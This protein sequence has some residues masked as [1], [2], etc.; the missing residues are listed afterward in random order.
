[1]AEQPELVSVREEAD[2]AR[3]VADRVLDY[4]EAG[5]ALKA[6]AVLFRASHHSGPLEV[7]LTRR[8]IP[9]VKFGGLRFVGA[10]RLKAIVALLRFRE[11]PRDRVAGSR[12]LQLMPGIGAVT[13]AHV[14]D[15]VEETGRPADAVARFAPP[16]KAAADWPA[17]S[18]LVGE[19][20]AGAPWPAEL[21]R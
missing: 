1:S 4:R 7:E 11:S 5:M 19:L 21:E 3:Y 18:A 20:A 6:Q 17:F 15:A 9:F 14:L 2:Q 16:A 13:A 8:N 10:A 12:V